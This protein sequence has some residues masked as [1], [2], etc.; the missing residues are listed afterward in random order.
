MKGCFKRHSVRDA[1]RAV[2]ALDEAPHRWECPRFSV[3][4]NA[5]FL[6]FQIAQTTD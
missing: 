5:V 1:E 3:R 4:L 2:K 6:P